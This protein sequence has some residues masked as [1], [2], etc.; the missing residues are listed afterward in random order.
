MTVLST[1]IATLLVEHDCV[2][3][4]H[5]GGFVANPKG[6]QHDQ[7][8][9]KFSPPSRQFS[10][11]SHLKHNDGLLIQTWAELNTFT[12]KEAEQQIS[13]TVSNWTSTLKTG[14][15]L[16][17][18]ELGAL[19]QTTDGRLIFEP[20]STHAKVSFGLEPF[21]RL[22]IVQ[23]IEEEH[24]EPVTPV[25]APVK[26]QRNKWSYAAAVLAIPVVGY[27]AYV[28][29]QTG[30]FKAD[31][32]FALADLNPFTE[33]LCELYEPRGVEPMMAT[34]PESDNWLQLTSDA[35]VVP[36]HLTE[37][38]TEET[39]IWVRLEEKKSAVIPSSQFYLI[40]G[41]FSNEVNA[42]N[43]VHT[44][45]SEGYSA[46]VVDYYKGLYRVSASAFP[47]RKK[48]EEALVTLRDTFAPSAWLLFK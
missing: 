15:R 24:I 7:V 18:P 11:N 28:A 44:L 29:T 1:H 23:T 39:T 20:S 26:H 21:H 25:V 19:H 14:E 40:A 46:Q 16:Q 3:V 4:P 43:L 5:F 9:H 10:F 48:A 38:T 34:L 2:I 27:M 32:Q 31:Q 8:T 41:C 17:L 47:T 45:T 30:L 6:A 35:P 33:K 13:T 36:L 22:P 42:K 12:Y 37:L